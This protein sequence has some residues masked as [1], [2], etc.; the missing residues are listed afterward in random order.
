MEPWVGIS[1]GT[2]GTPFGI[3]RGTSVGGSMA[4]EIAATIPSSLSEMDVGSSARASTFIS[5]STGVSVDVTVILSDESTA[6]DVGSMINTPAM[7]VA[8]SR[9][10][11][12]GVKIIVLSTGGVFV[13]EMEAVNVSVMDIADLQCTGIL[14]CSNT[15]LTFGNQSIRVIDLGLN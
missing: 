7:G 3:F 6:T 12:V 13:M 11:G 15:P 14:N 5:I 8:V 9:T 4:R 10:S 2:F 1:V